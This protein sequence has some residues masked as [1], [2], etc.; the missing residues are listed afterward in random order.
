MLLIL[1]D[2]LTIDVAFELVAIRNRLQSIPAV[3]LPFK[4]FGFEIMNTAAL[5]PCL[6][7]VRRFWLKTKCTQIKGVETR[8]VR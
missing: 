2:Q 8:N 3:Q 1:Q 5:R 4:R 7:N 6:E